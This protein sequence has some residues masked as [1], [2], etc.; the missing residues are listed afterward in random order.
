MPQQPN[1]VTFNWELEEGG[2][3]FHYNL[4]IVPALTQVWMG[5]ETSAASAIQDAIRSGQS[6]KESQT[7]ET[8]YFIIDP[9][10]LVDDH[11]DYKDKVNRF[12]KFGMLVP[13]DSESFDLIVRYNK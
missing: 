11:K 2:D 4:Y 3:T 13:E 1:S 10:R 5:A 6:K 8:Y 9:L 7:T 12:V